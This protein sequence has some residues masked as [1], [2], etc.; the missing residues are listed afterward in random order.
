[1]K[2]S[3]RR[4]PR[5][6]ECSASTARC[7]DSLHMVLGTGLDAQPHTRAISCQIEPRSASHWSNLLSN[8]ET[9]TDGHS[10]VRLRTWGRNISAPVISLPPYLRRN[11]TQTVHSHA[12]KISENQVKHINPET[13]H[14]QWDRKVLTFLTHSNIRDDVKLAQ[15]VRARDCQSRSCLFDSGKNSK[16]RELKSTWI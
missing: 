2:D 7:S 14:A 16:N 8:R 3:R 6:A 5:K 13:R 11:M 9:G 4:I 1:M 15:L 12:A 10:T